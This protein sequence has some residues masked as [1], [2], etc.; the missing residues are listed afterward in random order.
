[1]S[2]DYIIN[3][4]IMGVQ[5]GELFAAREL[6]LQ[7]I[8]LDKDKTHL[9]GFDAVYRNPK[10]GNLVVVDFKGGPH[11]A[12]KSNQKQADYMIKAADKIIKSDSASAKEKEA[13]RMVKSE[14]EKGRT[15]EFMAIKTPRFGGKTYVDHHSVAGR[16]ANLQGVQRFNLNHKKSTQLNGVSIH[17]WQKPPMRTISRPANDNNPSPPKTP[18]Q[19]PSRTANDIRSAQTKAQI[20]PTAQSPKRSR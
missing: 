12:L 2:K 15:V 6:K 14:L 18:S 11:S 9:H 1:M 3:K 8:M 19:S 16:A 5:N 20:Q 17:G 4:T 10:T 13:S 7:P